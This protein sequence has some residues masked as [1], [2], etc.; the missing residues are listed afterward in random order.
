MSIRQTID[1]IAKSSI[2][3]DL[4]DLPGLV[5]L[6]EQVDALR[7]M[8]DSPDYESLDSL[9]KQVSE[10]IEAIVLRESE[11]TE[12]AF[13]I[14][15]ESID[16]AADLVDAIEQGLKGGYLPRSPFD[17][18]PEEDSADDSDIDPELL[19]AWISSCSDTLND[20]QNAVVSLEGA[21]DPA[22]Y[23][24]EARRQIHTIK[25]EAGV[26]SLHIAQKLCHQAESLIDQCTESGEAFPVDNVL[27]L[28]DWL[29]NYVESLASDPKAAPPPYEEL[30]RKL[31]AGSSNEADTGKTDDTPAVSE[32][33]AESESGN[34]TEQT[35]AETAAET[36]AETPAAESAG[37][38]EPLDF[39][40]DAT[41]DE[42]LG[43]FI[44][45]AREHLEGSEGALL[46]IENSPEDLELINTVFRAFHTIK[47]VAGFLSLTPIVTLAHN[48]ETLLDKARNGEITLSGNYM[49]LVLQS[50]DMMSQ[51][52]AALEG[53]D[54]PSKGEHASL[55][56]KLKVATSGEAPAAPAND[57]ADSN[58]EAPPTPTE[59]V[60][61]EAAKVESP[62]QAETPA[63]VQSG[64]E[65]DNK[66]AEAQQKPE[67]EVKENKPPAEKTQ[68]NATCKTGGSGSK[69]DNNTKKKIQQTVKVSTERMDNLVR[70]VGELVIAQQM[71]VQDPTLVHLSDQRL[72]R[73]L[74]HSS[75]IIRDL[76]EVAM[77]LR[78]V[79]VKG[80]F[81]KMARL[82]RDIAKKSGKKINFVMEG[83]DTELDRTVVDKIGDPLVH[84][85]RNACDHGIETP[86]VRRAAGKSVTGTLTLRAYHQGG[87][88]IIEVQDDGNGLDRDRILTKAVSSGVIPADR[89]PEDL[90]D[91]EVYNLIFLPGFSTAKEVTDISGRGVGMDV[92]RRN[93]ESLRGSV[94]ITSTPGKGSAFRMRLP[95]T[96]AIIDGMVTRVGTQRYVIPTLAIEQSFRPTADQVETVVGRGEMAMV[97]GELLPIYRLNNILHLNEGISDPSEALLLVLETNNTR[98]CLLV[99]E[100]LGQQ[101]VVIKSLGLNTQSLRAVS[102]GAILGDGRVALILDVTGLIEEATR[103]L[104][105]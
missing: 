25:G 12:K 48:A 10:L 63:S 70:M 24:G 83:E 95:L 55:I 61:T 67:K 69:T 43:D 50:C 60:K 94:E 64:A 22:E 76:Q 102:G 79:T 75:K 68:T 2:K 3:V 101:Q 47:G 71:I 13:E 37:N 87:S 80:V 98:C 35:T 19:E 103:S 7:E 4:E 9:C 66:V 62:E 56:E 30:L 65:P 51:L 42:N 91:S 84:M 39:P 26:L 105:V 38:D 41:A 46:E 96:M 6:Q 86:E 58:Q 82:V 93:I 15:Q 1:N 33:S 52:I 74:G 29:R 89:N 92:V 11:D 8:I 78:L 5:A 18:A 28:T 16:Y 97:R 77:S 20:L 104:A 90:P 99:D 36:A 44:C 53:S 100:I 17:S 21:D 45:E 72:Q 57:S 31:Q 23:V 73:N 40:G 88:V 34:N 54:P 14:L 59:D 49:D 32:T 85:I 81:Q 27:E